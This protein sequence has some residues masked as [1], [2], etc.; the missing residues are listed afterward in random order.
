MCGIIAIVQ[1]GTF[2]ADEILKRLQCLAYRGYDSHGYAFGHAMR[3]G[4]GHIAI[5]PEDA[6]ISGTC[7]I[8][9]TRWATHGGVTIENAHPHRVGAV[10]LVHNGIIDNYATIAGARAFKS[11]TDSE[12]LA[13]RIDEDIS[14]DAPLN[15][16]RA[17]LKH[18]KG[19]WAIAAMVDGVD[20]LLIA[21]KH[22]P[23][24]IGKVKSGYV[25]AS[26][27][28]AIVDAKEILA[29]DDGTVAHITADAL[30]VQDMR[31]NAVPLH[32]E[33]NL[34]EEEER[35]EVGYAME[36]EILQI[37]ALLERHMAPST[38][39]VSDPVTII[40]CGSSINA[41]SIAVALARSRSRVV[42]ASEYDP[43]MDDT[44]T[45]VAVSQSGETADVLDAVRKAKAANRRI[46]CLVNAPHT[47]LTRLADETI[48]L[49]A[50]EERCVAATKSVILQV[51]ALAALFGVDVADEALIGA[52][53]A[54][55]D[56]EMLRIRARETASAEHV[57]LIGRG[58][59]LAVA[60]E[61]ALKL[62]EIPYQH[63][64]AVPALELKHGPLALITPEVPVLA[65]G[66][67]DDD[68]LRSTINEVSARAG[69]VFP[70]LYDAG[71][72]GVFCALVSLQLLAF[73]V[74]VL[75]GVPIDHP[76]NLAKSVTVY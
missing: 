18:A 38:I 41:A 4:I 23:L 33:R 25:I 6:A 63:A 28:R 48:L 2:R 12:R 76:R 67:V 30:T 22:V 57:F 5:L 17:A 21:R 19:I 51:I 69:R 35:P 54:L 47:T 66:D 50:G 39:S 7:A 1:R 10:T 3:K 13:A 8:A 11:E 65:L 29:L 53:A 24:I 42:L 16:L 62:K 36:H 32:W 74:A 75:R 45:L 70:F 59:W 37:P 64:E 49:G 61:A 31:G 14:V 43:M 9:H 72:A 44:R 15:G 60:H 34:V 55:A 71:P 46:I 73:E 26:D 52:R 68:R 56:R 40:G 58:A 27:A 20:G